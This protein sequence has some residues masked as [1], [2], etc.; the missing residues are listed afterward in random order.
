MDRW[1]IIN[2]D[3]VDYIAMDITT[4]P[5]YYTPLITEKHIS[6]RFLSSIQ[7]IMESDIDH[8]FRTTCIKPIV[9]AHTIENVT[10]IIKGAMLYAL[11]RFHYTRVLCPEFFQGKEIFHNESELFHL[12]ALAAPWVKKC[13]VR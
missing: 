11:Q 12:K 10:K 13:I 2:E 3:L 9:D 5:L 4:D 6:N 1:E 8:E 7:I